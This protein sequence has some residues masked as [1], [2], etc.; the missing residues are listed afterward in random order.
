MAA[1]SVHPDNTGTGPGRYFAVTVI[2]DHR[3]CCPNTCDGSTG[4]RNAGPGF[5]LKYHL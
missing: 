5:F 2:P 4:I 1:G 3:V